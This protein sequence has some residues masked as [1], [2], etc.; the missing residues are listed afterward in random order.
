MKEYRRK[1]IDIW[2]LFVDYGNSWEYEVAEYTR[3][4]GR[5]RLKEY[6][7]NCPQYPVELRKGR[8]SVNNYTPEQLAEILE[9]QGYGI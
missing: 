9:E 7:E 4:A 3:K 1:T 6:Q 5:K 2:R 8:E